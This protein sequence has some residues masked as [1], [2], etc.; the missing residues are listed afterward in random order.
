MQLVFIRNNFMIKKFQ[1]GFTLIEM[2]TT[3]AIMALILSLTVANIHGS[4]ASRNVQLAQS[5]LTSDLHKVQTYAINSQDY[6]AGAVPA[7]AWG[8][9]TNSPFTSYAITS[10]D[11][12]ITPTT[13]SVSTV[14]LPNAVSFTRVQ[15]VRPAGA[16]TICP[17]SMTVQFTVPYGRVL[18]SFTGAPCSGGGQVNIV[19]ES[20]DIIA[21]VLGYSGSNY[22]S[23][24]VING[25]SGNIV[26]Q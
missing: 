8:I 25:I 24:L 1:F 21:I 12:S 15:I 9:T 4:D 10:T 13:T 14:S 6:Y 3:I 2:M 19:Q 16:G 5:Q 18:T 7:S 26:T 22:T 23:T 17:T 11:N 20:N